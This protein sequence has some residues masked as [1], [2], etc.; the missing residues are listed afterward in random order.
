MGISKIC[1][2]HRSPYR[3]LFMDMEVSQ[4][5]GTFLGVPIIKKDYNI[6][7]SILGSPVLGETTIHRRSF[8]GS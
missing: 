4:N 7:E 2:K 1:P 3:G 6:L 8:E 5:Q